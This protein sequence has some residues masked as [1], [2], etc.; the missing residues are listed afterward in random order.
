MLSHLND[1]CPWGHIIWTSPLNCDSVYE[2]HINEMGIIFKYFGRQGKRIRYCHHAYLQ[3]N[4]ISWYKILSL[5]QSRRWMRWN[6]YCVITQLNYNFVRIAC[7]DGFY[8]GTLQLLRHLLTYSIFTFTSVSDWRLRIN[9]I[10]GSLRV[11][12]LHE[13][14]VS[15]QSFASNHIIQ[16]VEQISCHRT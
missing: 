5:S 13:S 2:W 6:P 8:S 1:L 9:A 12:T 16:Y 7:L 14:G 11:S 3:T 4:H 15:G 10:F